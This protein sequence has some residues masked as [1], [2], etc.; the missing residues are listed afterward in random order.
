MTDRLTVARDAAAEAGKLTLEY[1]QTDRF[2]VERKGDDSPVT[3]ADRNAETLLRERIT[4]AF[5]DD[6]I[7]G[8]EHEDK[9]GTSGYQWIL[10]PID[11]TKSFI[12]GVPLYGTLVG[13]L[14]KDEPVIG[15]IEIAGLDERVYAAKGEGAWYRRGDGEAVACQLAKVDSIAD[16]VFVTT[17]Y[18]GFLERGGGAE[19]VF[20]TL[21]RQA[22]IARTWG[23]CYGYLLV[24]TGRAH[25]MIDPLMNIWDAAALLPVITEAGGVYTD[26]QGKP[27]VESGEGIATTHEL[28]PH[29]LEITRRFLKPS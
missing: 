19:E 3:I 7:V 11:G 9:P 25:L 18:R 20:D 1:F 15:V 22:Y 6:A 10:D 14:H 26:W 21:S 13:V 2:D 16:G 12:S 29:V 5:P 4:A 27:S 8:E 17:A 28:L 23:D 24:A